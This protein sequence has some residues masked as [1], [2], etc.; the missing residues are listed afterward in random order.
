MATEAELLKPR[1][2]VLNH[3]DNWMPPLTP[4]GGTDLTPIR[5]ELARRAPNARLLEMGYLEGVSIL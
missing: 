2:I 5:E 1:T 4:A 3:H